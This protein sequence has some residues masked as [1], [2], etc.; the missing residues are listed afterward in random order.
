MNARFLV[1][2]L[3]VLFAGPV[4][5]CDPETGERQQRVS[6][7]WNNQSIEHWTVRLGE[8]RVIDLPNGFPLGLQFDEPELEVYQRARARFMPELLKISLFD[9]SE[10][11]PVLLSFTYGGT[12]SL[13]GYGSRGGADRVDELGDPGVT[14]HLHKPVCVELAPSPSD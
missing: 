10:P 5:A 12:N 6:L 3:W 13:Q 9:L 14:L 8:I 11:E 4:W 7:S 2:F 1:V